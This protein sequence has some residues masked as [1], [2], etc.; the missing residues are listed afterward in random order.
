MREPLRLECQHFIDCILNGQTPLSNGRNGVQVLRVL[1]AGQ[2]SL[3]RG[4]EP[5][6]LERN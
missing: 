1:E 4:G 5:M 3:E 2:H 6:R